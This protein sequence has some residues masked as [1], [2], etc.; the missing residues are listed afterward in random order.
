M[1]TYVEPSTEEVLGKVANLNRDDI[2]RAI[3][4]ADAAQREF[5]K[6]STAAGRSL[7]L[8]KW[9]DAILANADDCEFQ[10]RWSGFFWRQD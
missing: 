6:T 8:R 3:V 5:Y 2:K 9:N 7:L 10:M 1:V 4:S